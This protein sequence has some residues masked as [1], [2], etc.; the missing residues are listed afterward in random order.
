MTRIWILSLVKRGFLQE[1]EIF[2]DEQTACNRKNVLM[3]DLNPDYDE[4]GI[5][6]KTISFSGISNFK[7][8]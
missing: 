7:H 6:E 3:D 8:L 4:L 5:F 2:Y 1:P